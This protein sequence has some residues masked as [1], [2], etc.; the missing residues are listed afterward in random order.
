MRNSSGEVIAVVLLLAVIFGIP[1]VT[2]GYEYVFMPMREDGHVV[3]IVAR[4]PENGGFSVNAIEAFTDQPITLRFTSADVT[5]GI[6]IGPGLGVDLGH[7]DPGLTGEVTLNFDQ[8]GT[9]TIYC[10]TWCSP[11]HWRMRS[12]IQVRDPDN[13]DAI[14]TAQPDRVIEALIGEGIDIDAGLN[15]EEEDGH[16]DHAEE[17]A[18]SHT[19]SA[20]NGRAVLDSLTLPA[21][22]EDVEWRRTHSPDEAL[23]LIEI[24]NPSV[25]QSDLM[26]AIAIL[27]TM[28][29]DDA[30]YDMVADLYAKN[31]AACHGENGR[32]DGPAAS[33]TAVL[34]VAFD[35]WPHMFTMRDDVLY[36][37]IRRGGMG[38]DMP[39]FGTLFTPHE[40]WTLVD[41]IRTLP[42]VS[43]K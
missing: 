40:T 18:L 24:A 10:N 7:I 35:D 19:V 9:Y 17:V 27:W 43:Q 16:N 15:H 20:D 34:P 23:A 11:D 36:A 3:D 38:T 5:H 29:Q 39:N 37:K 8:P 22:V 26:D 4:S 33:M 1:G 25:S 30:L 32:A 13:P 6:A 12:V 14:P 41:Y 42:A 2:L 31:C 21:K 28:S